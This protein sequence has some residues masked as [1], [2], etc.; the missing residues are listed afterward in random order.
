MFNCE[1]GSK[2]DLALKICKVI[3]QDIS[4]ELKNI[5]MLKTKFP[6]NTSRTSDKEKNSLNSS[7]DFNSSESSKTIIVVR[8]PSDIGRS[9]NDVKVKLIKLKRELEGI[10]TLI[11][12]CKKK[13]SLYSTPLLLQ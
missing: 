12:L 1:E 10:L 2:F 9:Q 7:S 11:D 5:E 4:L 13:Y 6:S 8:T 3:E